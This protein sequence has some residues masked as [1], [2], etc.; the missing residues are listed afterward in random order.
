MVPSKDIL[1]YCVVCSFGW[2]EI[3]QLHNSEYK[4]ILQV[5]VG[6]AVVAVKASVQ[7]VA[8]RTFFAGGYY[9]R[10]NAFL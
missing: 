1:E 7:K 9:L 5:P 2:C 8:T 3:Y 10:R 4:P 6:Q